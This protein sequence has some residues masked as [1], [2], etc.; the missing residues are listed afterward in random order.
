MF[1]HF[2]P[3]SIGFLSNVSTITLGAPPHPRHVLQSSLGAYCM[4]IGG[5]VA[6]VVRLLAPATR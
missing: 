6:A 4:D 1:S 2:Q 3:T 5:S